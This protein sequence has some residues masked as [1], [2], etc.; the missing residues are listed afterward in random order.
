MTAT[1]RSRLRENHSFWKNE[2]DKLVKKYCMSVF[3]FSEYHC[4]IEEKIDVWTS[5]KYWFKGTGAKGDLKNIEQVVE[6]IDY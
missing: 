3:W 1:K 2:I 5:G 6:L 4:R